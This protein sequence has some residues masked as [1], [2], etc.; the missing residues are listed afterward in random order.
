M[1]DAGI[2]FKKITD[3][4]VSFPQSLGNLLSRDDHLTE[5]FKKS[6]YRG[7]HSSSL[8]ARHRTSI[9]APFRNEMTEIVAFQ[10]EDYLRATT[11]NILDSKEMNPEDAKTMLS[12]GVFL[13]VGVSGRVVLPVELLERMGWQEEKKLTFVGQGDFFEIRN[14]EYYEH[15]INSQEET[16]RILDSHF[17]KTP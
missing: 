8:D 14:A 11:P 17:E 9:P 5:I 10:Y 12:K 16:H 6:V 13:S 15:M 3:A 4:F 7:C 2:N 1:S